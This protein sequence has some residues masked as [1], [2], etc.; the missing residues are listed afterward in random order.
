M[1]TVEKSNQCQSYWKG[2]SL[3]DDQHIK[4]ARIKIF[5]LTIWHHKQT[6]NCNLKEFENKNG[7]G[8]KK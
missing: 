3:Y 7:I 5:G 2:D 1:I 8:F 4:T 6:Y